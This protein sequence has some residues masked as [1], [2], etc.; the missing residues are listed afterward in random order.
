MRAGGGLIGVKRGW[1]NEREREKGGKSSIQRALSACSRD[2]ARPRRCIQ[3][4]ISLV[5]LKT[6]VNRDKSGERGVQRPVDSQT[7]GR[8]PDQCITP[9]GAVRGIQRARTRETDR[10]RN[11]RSKRDGKKDRQNENICERVKERRRE[12]ERANG[13]GRA[14]RG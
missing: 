4:T 7:G 13:Q 2:G 9:F 11:G 1:D 5:A 3:T 12:R 8:G 14:R 10:V 6:S